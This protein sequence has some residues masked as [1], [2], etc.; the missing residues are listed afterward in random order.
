MMLLYDLISDLLFLL[1]LLR[2]IAIMSTCNQYKIC[3][4]I[5]SM[6]KCCDLSIWIK[7][8]KIADFTVSNALSFE[9]VIKFT[10]AFLKQSSLFLNIEKLFQILLAFLHVY[11]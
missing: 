6:L 10:N 3:F 9:T 1:L 7:A 11:N 5:C 8:L 4:F 2:L